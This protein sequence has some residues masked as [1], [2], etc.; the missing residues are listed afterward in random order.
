[1]THEIVAAAQVDRRGRVNNIAL[2]K[3]DGGM[4]RLPGQGGMAD[5]ANMHRDYVLY[6]T[7]HSPLSVVDA[8]EIV[9]SARALLTPAEREPHG[10]RTG[11]AIVITNLCVFALDASTREL[12]VVETMPGVTREQIREATGFA[13]TFAADCRET[14]TPTAA[15]LAVLRER[16][17]PLGLRRLEFVGAKDRGGLIA[18]ILRGDRAFVERCLEAAGDRGPAGGGDG[19]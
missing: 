7:R 9:S 2:R 4:I 18:E 17:D 16:V 13:V 8:V 1:V 6:V 3:R 11:R 19:A 14:A 15:T 10:Y 12:V 5:V